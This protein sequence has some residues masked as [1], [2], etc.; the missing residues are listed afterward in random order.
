MFLFSIVARNSDGN[1]VNHDQ[2]ILIPGACLF[3]RHNCVFLAASKQ[4]T[5]RKQQQK[6]SVCVC[7]CFRVG[8]C[9]YMYICVYLCRSEGLSVV[10]GDR[11][12]V[13]TDVYVRVN[14]MNIDKCNNR[15]TRSSRRSLLSNGSKHID[16]I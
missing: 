5:S 11:C 3:A 1:S 6:D 14:E 15:R 9:I 8:A 7:V 2:D 10:R 12:G 13:N 4:F 16:E